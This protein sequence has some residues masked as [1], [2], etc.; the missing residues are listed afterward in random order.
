MTCTAQCFSINAA[1][2]GENII[3][4]EIAFTASEH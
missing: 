3:L 4:T 2:L 1:V